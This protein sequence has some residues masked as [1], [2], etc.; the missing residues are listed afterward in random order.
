MKLSYY[1]N[2]ILILENSQILNEKESLGID[3]FDTA[4]LILD[5]IQDNSKIRDGKPC[6][7]ITHGVEKTK[8][9]AE[10]LKKKAFESI[11]EICNERRI[12]FMGKL[13]ARFLL[14]QLH[15]AIKKGQEIDMYLESCNEES[16]S[17]ESKYYQ[18]IRLFT[19]GHIKYSFLLGFFFSQKNP[20][21]KRSIIQIGEKIGIVR[22]IVDDLNDY[23]KEHHE[24]LG[25]LINHKKRLP[26]LLFFLNST[27]EQK[28]NLK[29]ILKN[30]EDS[31]FEIVSMVLNKDVVIQI[32]SKIE[33]IKNKISLEMEKVP[34]NYSKSLKLLMNKF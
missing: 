8:Q 29:N 12:G 25:D 4:I 15:S 6:F 21:Y 5:D 20:S 10:K 30:T 1:I 22:Q 7:Y 18:M 14:K 26:E 13:R 32:N 19:G 31:Y 2:V 17:L 27:D 33:E 3:G 16:R 9:E 23:K 11:N 24:P 28:L 34:I